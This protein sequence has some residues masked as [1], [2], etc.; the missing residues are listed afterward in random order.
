MTYDDTSGKIM[1]MVGGDWLSQTNTAFIGT[2]KKSRSMN[3]TIG[4]RSSSGDALQGSITN[5]RI[6]ERSLDLSKMSA[7]QL[8]MDKAGRFM[9]VPG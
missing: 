7:D 1:V 2:F 4:G 9:N 5:L 8:F 6:Y 3:Y